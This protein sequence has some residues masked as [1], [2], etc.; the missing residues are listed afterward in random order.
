MNNPNIDLFGTELFVGGVVV[1][2]QDTELRVVKVN[3]F[4][5]KGIKIEYRT[6]KKK[7]LKTKLLYSRVVKVPELQADMWLLQNS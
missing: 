5:S 1:I 6:A 7:E 3:K 4:T 2:P